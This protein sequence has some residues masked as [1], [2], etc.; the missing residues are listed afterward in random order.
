V[1]EGRADKHKGGV[2]EGKRNVWRRGRIGGLREQGPWEGCKN[3]KGIEESF[4][5]NRKLSWIDKCRTDYDG[6]MPICR[7]DSRQTVKMPMPD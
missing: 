6:E 4:W 1:R 5:R 3:V 7:I 2:Q